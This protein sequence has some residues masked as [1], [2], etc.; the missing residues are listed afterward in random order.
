MN[1]T[2]QLLRNLATKHLF[3]I[4]TSQEETQELGLIVLDLFD[5]PRNGRR[6]LYS[7]DLVALVSDFKSY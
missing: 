2:S 4:P 5:L 7:C 3:I 6:C 1:Q